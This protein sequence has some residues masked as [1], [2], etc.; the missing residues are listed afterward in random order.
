MLLK[1]EDSFSIIF[2]R[3][4][5]NGSDV[6]QKSPVDVAVTPDQET[7]RFLVAFTDGAMEEGLG[8]TIGS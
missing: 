5:A 7:R 4:L 2:W 6:F 1:R 3:R 8:T